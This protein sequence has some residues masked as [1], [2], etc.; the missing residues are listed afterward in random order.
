[1]A[2]SHLFHIFAPDIDAYA[3]KIAHIRRWTHDVAAVAAFGNGD[4]Y[5]LC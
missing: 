4:L 1:L 3:K 5:I 2:F